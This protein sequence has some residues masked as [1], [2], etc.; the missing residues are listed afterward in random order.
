VSGDRTQERT[1]GPVQ[2]IRPAVEEDQA[3]RATRK[4]VAGE[5]ASGLESE[6]GN[7]Q[8]S[9][10]AEPEAGVVGGGEIVWEE[11]R[12]KGEKEEGVTAVG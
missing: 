1:E 8:E 2:D 4:Q 11:G 3:V 10:S 6:T 5:V 7:T 12:A 9:S